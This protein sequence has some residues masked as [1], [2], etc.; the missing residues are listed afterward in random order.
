MTR[1]IVLPTAWI[2]DPDR[3]AAGELARLLR[4]HGYAHVLGLSTTVDGWN[5]VPVDCLFIRITLWDDYLK[6]AGRGTK[7]A[8]TTVIFLSARR[9]KCTGHL[10]MVLDFHLQP[11]YRPS[12]LGAIFTCRGTPGFEPRPL[13]FFFLK[14][15]CRFEVIDFASLLQIRA[16]NGWLTVRT[17]GQEYTISGTITALQNRLPVTLHRVRRGLF[18]LHHG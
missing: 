7:R 16:D 8:A 18:V 12:R 14:V 15:Q 5:Q 11:P 13:D 3:D 9:E 2:I 10:S 17:E 6:R 4:T 1:A